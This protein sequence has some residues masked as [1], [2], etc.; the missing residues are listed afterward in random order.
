MEFLNVA[1]KKWEDL[2][3]NRQLVHM[4]HNCNQLPLDPAIHDA[5]L[6]AIRNDEYRNYTPPYGFEELRE[7]IGQDIGVPAV[8]VMVAQGATEAIY[9]AMSAIL[10]PGDQTIV[11]DPGWPHI[12]NFA[13]G[14]G[15]EVIRV[16][17]YSSNA[18]YKLRA[19]LVR[20][21]LTP[22]VKLITIIDPLNPLGSNY[23]EDEI[24]E[25]CAI[26]E[27][28][29]AFLLHDATYRDFAEGSHYPAVGCSER[30]VMNVSMSKICGFAGLRVGA[31][32]AH[33]KLFEKIA[34]KQVGRLGGNWVAQRGAVAAYQ[35]KSKWMPEVLKV[36]RENQL[37]IKTCLDQI[38]G[39]RPIV[40]PSFGNFLAVD[41]V[42]AGQGAEEVVSNVLEH[43]IIIRSGAYTSDEFGSRFVRI[44]TTVPSQDVH[45]L[46]DVLP[47]AV[48]KIHARD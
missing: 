24:R 17:V 31:T 10:Q 25:L 18:G 3:L 36:N 46:C 42:T 43:G 21:R 4:G 47:R 6:E 19:E 20:E 11:S 39:L 38:D 14:L 12:G 48:A 34:N 28:N 37:A 5:M 26:A 33:P 27:E 41:V 30:A 16:P 40:F 15:S 22:A 13:R 44:T 32:L 1:G 35:T 8:K 2:A 29:D 45:H 23:S 7:L 9:Q